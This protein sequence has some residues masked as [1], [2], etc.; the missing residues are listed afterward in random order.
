MTAL[1]QLD[2]SYNMLEGEIWKSPIWN[3]CTLR[4]LSLSAN[5]FRGRVQ[6]SEISDPKTLF[7][8]TN[9]S[10]EVLDLRWNPIMGLFPNLRPF[11]SLK[12]LRLSSSQI[13]G[14]VHDSVEELSNLEILDISNNSLEGVVSEAHF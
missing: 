6:V 1:V 7:K 5:R 14:S 11:S 3:V 4:I 2:L 12:E 9:Y 13:N 10:L 8:C